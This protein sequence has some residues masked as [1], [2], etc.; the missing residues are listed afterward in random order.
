MHRVRNYEQDGGDV[1]DED[2]AHGWY[3]PLPLGIAEADCLVS[4]QGNP[5]QA[6]AGNVD[7]RSLEILFSKF[8]IIYYKSVYY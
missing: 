6:Q 2:E 5:H 3:L 8:K 1:H 4:V 7:A